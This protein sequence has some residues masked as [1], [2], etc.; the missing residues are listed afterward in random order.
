MSSEISVQ[1][2]Q[3]SNPFPG[4]RPF[5]YEESHLFFGRESQVHEVIEKLVSKEFV[6]ILGTSGVGK[7]SFLNC[8]ILPTLYKGYHTDFSDDW[9]VF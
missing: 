5:T 4:L 2:E 9:E 3:R 8:G 1:L 7:S 6:A